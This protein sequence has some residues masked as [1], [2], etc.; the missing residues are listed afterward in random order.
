MPDITVPV[1]EA[2]VPEFFKWYG[3]WLEGSPPAPVASKIVSGGAETSEPY[4]YRVRPRWAD[5]AED[6]ARAQVLW[7]KMTAPARAI[8]D[9]LV[10]HPGKRFTGDE[11]ADAADIPHGAPGVAGTLTWPSRYCAG[12]D[13]QLPSEW[14]EIACKYWV[15]PE[16]ASLFDKVRGN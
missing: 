4:D 1:P 12:M 9:F 13:R 14:D 7:S 10:S 8:I 15:E 3:E 11:I 5:T 2:R 16:V 6:L